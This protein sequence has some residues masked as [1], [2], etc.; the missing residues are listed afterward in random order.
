M[1]IKVNLSVHDLVDFLLRTGDIDT[2][3]FNMDTMAK[4]TI[5]HRFY[6]E[7]QNS[8]YI[9]EYPFNETY[10]HHDYSFTLLGRADGL[11]IEN[12]R[13]TIEEVKSTND[14]IEY[15]YKT[16]KNWHLGQA[17]CYAFMYASKFNISQMDVLLTYISQVD[18]SKEQ[19]RFTYSYSELKVFFFELL[20]QYIQFHEHIRKHREL[21][22]KTAEKIAFPFLNVRRGQKDMISVTEDVVKKGG[23]VYIEAPTG[24]G[25][26][27]SVLYPSVKGFEN[28]HIEKVFYFTAKGSGQQ[29]AFDSFK[30]LHNNGLNA[31]AVILSA[32]EKVCL[33]D[34]VSC[35]PDDCPFARNYF[36]KVKDALLYALQHYDYFDKE[37]IQEIALKFEICPFEFQLD[38]SLFIDLIIGDYNYLFDPQVYLR[39]FFEVTTQNYITLIDETHNLIERVRD[40]YSATIDLYTLKQTKNSLRS[41]GDTKVKRRLSKLIKSIEDLATVVDEKESKIIVLPEE[42]DKA[43]EK[44]M[45]EAQ[46]FMKE[47]P[48]DVEDAFKDSFFML[49]RFL[50]LYVNFDENSALYT[51]KNG[52]DIKSINL[53]CLNP[54]VFIGQTLDKVYGS[55]LFSATLAPLDYYASELA[56][57]SRDQMIQL[58]NPFPKDNLLLLAATNVATTYKKRD[59][60]Y[61]L[62]ADYILAATKNRVGNFLVFC[63]SYAYLDKMLGYLETVDSIDLLVQTRDMNQTSRA[64]FLNEFRINPTTTTIGLTVVGGIFS[65]GVDLVDDRLSGVI[66]IGVGFPSITFDKELI[67]KYYDDNGYNGF[68]NAYIAPGI[69]RVLQAMGRVIRSETDKGFILLIDQRYLENRYRKIIENYNGRLVYVDEPQSIKYTLDK[70]FSDY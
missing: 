52:G 26:T 5:I 29:T 14:E 15:F 3:V 67:R 33:N 49:N 59:D 51:V 61:G 10:E 24:I 58:E 41:S 28:D 64:A 48:K 21:R 65:E 27:M 31:K 38:L 56:K 11:I 18:D 7:R 13:V 62:V 25:K 19:H 8:N 36:S 35:N 2:R 54:K 40:S 37:V 17:K 57:K 70:F 42:V 46:R 69:N 53:L 44:F 23:K 20:D 30:I 34:K 47:N 60:T 45:T 55:V 1:L 63:P 66:I 50:K 16:N 39:R 6:Q 32:K 4:G 22:A 43:V 9:A 12:E 68:H